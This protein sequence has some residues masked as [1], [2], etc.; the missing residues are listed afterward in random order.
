MILSGDTFLIHYKYD[1]PFMF[2]GYGSLLR[3]KNAEGGAETRERDSA[4]QNPSKHF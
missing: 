2:F 4:L 1:I 3:P